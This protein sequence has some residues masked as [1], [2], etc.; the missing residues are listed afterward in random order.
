MQAPFSCHFI[1]S[2]A[3]PQ[4][5][6]LSLLGDLLEVGL[7]AVL[8]LLTFQNMIEAVPRCA[9]SGSSVS[10]LYVAV[11]LADLVYDELW[12]TCQS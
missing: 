8:T 1:A 9:L 5:F 6:Q 2:Q 3:L 12:F 11:Q 10:R 4:G 7:V